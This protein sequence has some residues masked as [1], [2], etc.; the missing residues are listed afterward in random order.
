MNRLFER[1]LARIDAQLPPTLRAGTD[2]ELRRAR[3]VMLFATALTGFAPVFVLNDLKHG[4]WGNA[5]GVL[6]AVPFGV[7]AGRVFRRVPS[8]PFMGNYVTAIFGVVLAARTFMTGGI[9]AF[10]PF[11]L[12]SLPVLSMLL[13]GR[14][15]AVR[16]LAV[17]AVFN[18]SI[19]AATR[20]GVAWM[21]T[22]TV[23]ERQ[24]EFV[25]ATTMLG[26]LMLLLATLFEEAR[27]ASHARVEQRER[28][29]RRMLDVMGQGFITL[30]REGTVIGPHS[31]ALAHWLG[32]PRQ[33]MRF[34]DLVAPWDRPA[35]AWLAV[36]FEGLVEDLMPLEVLLDQ[37]PWVIR[38][39]ARRLAVEVKPALRRD[40][41][42]EAVV[43]VLSDITDQLEREAAEAEQRE[44]VTVLDRA[45]RDR[46]G[47]QLFVHEAARLVDEVSATG[48]LRAVHTIKGNAALFGAEAISALCHTLERQALD[49][50]ADALAPADRDTLKARWEAFSSRVACLVATRDDTFEVPVAEI[51]ALRAGLQRGI[52]YRQLDAQVSAWVL[53]PMAVP[54]ERLA[55]QARA[56]AL[57]LEKPEPRT[58]IEDHGLRVRSERWNPIWAVCAHLVRNAVDHGLE[59]ATQRVSV[60]KAPAGTLTF[61]ARLDRGQC[62]L[63]VRD[64]GRGISWERVRE[65]ARSQGLA[66]DTHDDLVRALFADGVSTAE[67]VSDVSGRGLGMGA[68]AELCRSHGGS[69]EV[70]SE[71]GAGTTVRLRLPAEDVAQTDDA[72]VAA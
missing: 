58:V 37:F 28:D 18:A 33:G 7:F 19:F 61:R 44:L 5:L 45:L 54:L 41:T 55:R 16:W 43:L 13:A 6:S 27:A 8:L 62:V 42:L 68:V 4:R 57:R 66:A 21:D 46:R 39:G 1:A 25:I 26:A 47:F 2:D 32:E 50:E 69:L 20:L 70:H 35:A 72:R 34:A 24:R 59:D 17:C 29:M 14:R 36:S 52:D 63:E 10:A 49:A 31:A 3:L 48:S 38:C 11:W 9:T 12:A 23:A 64:D 51:E 22:W 60:G 53:E 67:T 15:S 40:G 71:P 65:R 30:S 56:L